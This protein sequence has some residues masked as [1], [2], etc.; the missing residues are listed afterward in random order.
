M[1]LKSKKNLDKKQPVF[2]TPNLSRMQVVVIDGKTSIYI[3][4]DA[5]PE[6]ARKRYMA[7]LATR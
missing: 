2:K 5:D 7:R 6:Q 3:D 1:N 4:P